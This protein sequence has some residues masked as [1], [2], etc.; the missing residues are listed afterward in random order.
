MNLWRKKIRPDPRFSA[1][2]LPPQQGRWPHHRIFLGGTTAWLRDRG[3]LGIPVPVPGR[4]LEL[5]GTLVD[6]SREFPTAHPFPGLCVRLNGRELGRIWPVRPGPFLWYFPL[7]PGGVPAGAVLS[8]ELRGVAGSNF[9]AWI[10]RLLQPFPL[11][12]GLY[13]RLQEYR[14]QKRNRQLRLEALRVDGEE[15]IHFRQSRLTPARRLV[16]ASWQPGLNLVGFFRAALGVGESVR[17]AARA[18][19]AAGLPAAL[20]DLRLNCLNPLIDDTYAARLQTANPHPVNV[21]HLDAPQSEEIDHHHGRGFRA[22]RYN[23]GYWAWELP[24]FPDG[25]VVHHRF[26]DE[27]WCPSEFAR[28]AIAAKVPKPV[29]AMPHAIDFPVPGGDL[30]P[31][32]NLPARTFLFLFVYDLNSTQERKNPR[33]VIAAFRRAFPAGGP[34]GLVIKTHNPERNPAALAE[35]AAELHGLPNA[36]LLSATLPRTALYELQ[37]AC[38]C[39]VSLH[40]A[41]GFG[42]NVAECMFLGKPVIATDWSGT[43]EFVNAA[44]GCPISYRLVTLADDHGPYSRG[45]TWAEPDVDHAAHWMRRLVEDE[46]LRT[47]L[48]AQ[49]AADIRR[50]FSPAVIGRRYRQRLDTFMLW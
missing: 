30:R 3:A 31:R 40:R 13:R 46:A 43:A 48:G 10:G 38:D 33:A 23:V 8:F 37:Q 15:I 17:C 19:D 39:F 7:P 44:N 34:V 22:G 25:W 20:I 28:A 49:A 50:L 6:H 42:L 21:F 36:H 5:I 32:F 9:L 35:L 26:F 41:E 11:S 29:L 2:W 47:R 18:A 24:E 45:Y 14:L 4:R 1:G 27:I 16:A 12:G